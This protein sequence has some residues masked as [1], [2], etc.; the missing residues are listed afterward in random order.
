MESKSGELND[1]AFLELLGSYYHDRLMDEIELLDMAGEEFDLSKVLSGTLT[2]IFFGS[3]MTNFGVLPFL[4]EFIRM[5]PCPQSKIAGNNIIDPV[6]SPFSG[7]IFKIQANMNPAHRDRL[8]FLRICSGKFEKGG[9]AYGNRQR[10][11][12]L[13]AYTVY[14]TGAYHY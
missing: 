12:S 7:F 14:G 2:P 4:E 5:A 10:D 3:A 1:P 11:T 8:A 6:T 9:M 13:A